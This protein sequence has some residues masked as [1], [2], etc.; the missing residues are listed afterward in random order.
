MN[1][2]PQSISEFRSEFSRWLKDNRP[3]AT[4]FRLPETFMEVST[5]E[6]FSFLR[7]WQQRVHKAGYLGV[8]WPTEFGGRSLPFE[9]QTVIDA[10]MIR[11]SV[12]VMFNTIGLNW[13]G[14]LILEMGSDEQKTKY[15]KG[16]LTGDDVWCQGF[17]EPGAGSD[18]ADIRTTAVRDGDSWKIN[19]SKIWTTLGSYAKYMILLAKGD[20]KAPRYKGM[21]FLLIPMDVPG[22]EVH[23]IQKMTGEFGFCE[24]FF[25]DV[26]VPADCL[27]GEE[28][29]GWRVAMRTLMYERGAD[30]GQAGR[31]M[32]TVPDSGGVVDLVQRAQLNGAPALKDPLIRDELVKLLIEE[33]ANGLHDQRLKH[34]ALVGEFP[35]AVALSEKLRNSEWNRRLQRLATE[36]Q[37]LEG[38]LYMGDE[39][40]L[41]DGAWQRGYFNAFSATIG[42]GPSQIQANIVAERVL[43][44]PKD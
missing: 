25:N 44:L 23:K 13:A 29:G 43:G 37:G 34:P 16:I 3:S 36:L 40:A 18:L 11:Q 20:L 31:H 15:L 26:R 7:D 32:G 35:E 1:Q 4:P 19:G 27:I 38:A 8:S 21:N 12:P 24:V 5:D 42:G 10:E 39:D 6:Q 22:I 2:V 33:R 14:P 28:G 9:Y 30:S 41:D 17:S